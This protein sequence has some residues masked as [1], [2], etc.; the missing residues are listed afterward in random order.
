MKN[1]EESIEEIKK[2]IAIERLRQAPS[3]F[4]IS[5]GSN[6]GKFM[7]RDDLIKEVEEETPAGENII[8]I[9]LEYLRAFKRGFLTQ[10][11]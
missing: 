4:S 10:N 6:G 8:N 2:K 7:N 1:K 3:N 9:Q 5:L 11:G